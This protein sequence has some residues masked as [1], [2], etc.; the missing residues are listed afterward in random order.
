[1][2]SAAKISKLGTRMMPF[3]AILRQDL[4][5]LWASRL[6]RLWLAANRGRGEGR[7]HNAGYAAI[8]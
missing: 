4:G 5:T 2:D 1:M 7:W 8:L 3:M 6:V